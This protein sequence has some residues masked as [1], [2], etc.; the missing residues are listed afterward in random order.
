MEDIRDGEGKTFANSADRKK[1]IVDFYAK[2]YKKPDD[3]PADVTGCIENFLGQEI[4]EN[5]I[6]RDSK[7]PRRLAQELESPISLAEL[8]ISVKQGNR[9]AAGMDGLSNCF[10]KKF[11]HLLRILLHRYVMLCTR[12]G[13]LTHT[14][15]TA[16]IRIIQKKATQRKLVTGGLFRS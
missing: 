7:I 15:R 4:C 3:D 13:S 14:F 5:K 12:K 8:D 9:S 6:V 2:L 16:K 11:W 1:F 10:I